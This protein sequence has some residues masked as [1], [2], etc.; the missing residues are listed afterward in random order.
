MSSARPT[1]TWTRQRVVAS[2]AH[3]RRGLV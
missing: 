2:V 1:P 3:A